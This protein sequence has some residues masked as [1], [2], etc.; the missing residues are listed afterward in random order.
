MLCFPGRVPASLSGMTCARA[1]KMFDEAPVGAN[2]PLFSFVTE[3]T[4]N[5]VCA[6]L[7]QN[8]PPLIYNKKSTIKIY[9]TYQATLVTFS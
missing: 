4:L 6:V 9:T 1:V 8:F 2:S 7:S 3:I 5:L